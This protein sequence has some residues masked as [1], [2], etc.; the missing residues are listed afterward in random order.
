MAS[1]LGRS[2]T[3]V[4]RWQP[5]ERRC[6]SPMKK[7]AWGPTPQALYFCVPSDKKSAPCEK[8]NK[9][10][11]LSTILVDQ[12]AKKVVDSRPDC[13]HLDVWETAAPRR[14]PALLAATPLATAAPCSH[15]AR[16]V[17]PDAAVPC[18][19]PA[20]PLH[21]LPL[22]L[23]IRSLAELLWPRHWALLPHPPSAAPPPASRAAAP[24]RGGHS[25]RH[26]QRR[27][28]RQ[29]RQRPHAGVTSP[30]PPPPPPAPGLP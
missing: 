30:Y 15:S 20:P 26:W 27:R 11:V 12:V 5:G 2:M 13:R 16:S 14:A 21:P 10:M 19:Q 18:H 1:H 4:R 9:T 17:A 28:Q 8:K 6:R 23:S 3:S 24:R 7:S 29:R 22:P 25:N